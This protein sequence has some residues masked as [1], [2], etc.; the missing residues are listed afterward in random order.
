MKIICIRLQ[1]SDI[2]L[3]TKKKQLKNGRESISPKSPFFFFFVNSLSRSI[4]WETRSNAELV[5]RINLFQWKILNKH[6]IKTHTNYI[7]REDWPR[8]SSSYENFPLTSVSINNIASSAPQVT[9]KYFLHAVH[10][11]RRFLKEIRR[12]ITISWNISLETIR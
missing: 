11:E 10:Q 5:V 8:V 3:T 6:W 4:I 9:W 12:S 2:L 7:R 1:K